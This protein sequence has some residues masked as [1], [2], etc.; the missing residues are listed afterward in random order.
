MAESF[1]N[2][3]QKFKT[4]E[5]EL[6]FLRK[7]VS[8]KEKE[9]LEDGNIVNKEKLLNEKI[10]EYRKTESEQILNKDYIIP[11]KELNSIVLELSP[12]SHDSKISELI[13]ILQDKGVFNTL[14]VIGRL[15][16]PHLEDDFH[17]FLVQYIK[18]GFPVSNI[19][20][21]SPIFKSLKM[22]LFEVSLPEVYEDEQKG[23]N[24]KEII[25]KM[26]QFYS[27]MFSVASDE[28]DG[29][30]YFVLELANSNNSNEIVFYISVPDSKKILFEKQLVSIFPN[31]R[32]LEKKDDYNIFNEGG[33]YVG[34]YAEFSANDILPI[35]TYDQYD[36][37]PLKIILNSF[38]KVDKETE[39]AAIQI[40]VKP[41][42]VEK[43]SFFKRVLKEME[44]GLKFKDAL[45][46]ADSSFLNI[47]QQ[48]FR[49]IFFSN[50]KDEKKD[51][52]SLSNQVPIENIKNKISSPLVDINIRVMASSNTHEEADAIL[53]D[54]ESV[55]NQFEN[56]TGNKIKF[57]RVFGKDLLKMSRDFSFRLFNFSKS[58]TLNLKELTTVIHLPEID[59]KVNSQLKQT[60]A[61]TAPAP[62][63]LSDQGILLGI[64]KFRGID[65]EIK[66]TPEDRLRHFYVIG[67]TGTGK[68][69]LL[70]TMIRQDILNGDGVCMIDPHGSDIQEVLSYIPKERYED[71]IYFDPSYVERPMGLNMLEYDVR[72]PEQKTFVVNEM[73][74]IFNK[75]FDMK[76]AGGPM[77]E[78]YFRNAT[79]LVIEDPETGCTLLDVSRVLADKTF[80]QLKLSRCKNPIVVQFWKEIAEKAGGEASLSNIVPYITSKFDVFLSNEI[81][82]PIVAQEKSSFNF[83]E[84]MDDKKILLVNLAKGRLGDVNSN[85]LGLIIVGKLLMAALSRV[86]SFGKELPP[87]YL[88]IDEFQNVTTDSISTILSEARKYKLSLT[89]AHQFIA[90]LDEK[91]KDSVFGNVGS[92]SVF[93]V[94]SEDSEYLEKQFAPVFSAKDLMNVDNHNSFVKMLSGGRPVK[95][96]SMETNLPPRGTKILLDKI[97]ELSYLKYGKDREEVENIIMEK[98]KKPEVKIDVPSVQKI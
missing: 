10:E 30:G 8:R 72:F 96:F 24:L 68:T 29:S 22:T 9:L 51:D 53:S 61:N 91:I 89:I 16:D 1:S 38:S 3:E 25:S 11:E 49:E 32:V 18:A 94:S 26:E 44:K 82:R 58:I 70:K 86:D 7:E 98:Y 4:P 84:I 64:N 50:K 14:S 23:K 65:T 41:S 37:D 28:K 43:M 62:M 97:K 20:E 34:S 2:F 54:I 88:Y 52:S 66:I 15:K 76:T 46:K 36:Y 92:M 78:Q 83:R 56:T 17:R 42:R 39:G 33:D 12:E 57:K 5:E 87:F 75:L 85:L 59:S 93:R 60:K 74:S 80:R 63:D 79:M 31:V 81:M 48:V 27:G 45:K 67:Q 40:I 77:F 19:K 69:T 6:D 21:K 55:F 71:V 47:S 35:K 73:M 90:Q 13:N 95:P